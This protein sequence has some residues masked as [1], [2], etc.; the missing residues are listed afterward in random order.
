MIRAD[1]GR[2]RTKCRSGLPQISAASPK[3]G[4][5]IAAS[6][7]YEGNESGTGPVGGDQFGVAQS[8]LCARDGVC[9]SAQCTD[10]DVAATQP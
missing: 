10:V 4:Q 8:G 9:R 1:E 6:A 7:G 5:R 2:H 3:V